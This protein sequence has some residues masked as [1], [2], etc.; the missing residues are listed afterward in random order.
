MT[1]NSGIFYAF[2]SAF[3]MGTIGVSTKL[4]I[5]NFYSFS[6]VLYVGIV[7]TLMLFLYLLFK[8]KHTRI[9]SEFKLR[10]IYY[11]LVGIL[12]MG[13][14][15]FTCITSY[16]FLP[17]SEVVI[18]V[19]TYPLLMLIFARL[20]FKEKISFKSIGFILIGFLGVYLLITKGS[21]TNFTFNWGVILALL[22]SISWG[23]YSIIIKNKKLDVEI[24]M[25]LY[26]FFGTIFL[27]FLSPFFKI[28]FKFSVDV[29]LG[30]L[31]IAIIPV[32]LAFVFWNKA[33]RVTKTTI[34]SGIILL[35]PLISVIL[36]ILFLGENL[37]L[38]QLLGFLIILIAL[39][40]NFYFQK[41][42]N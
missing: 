15:Q 41:K 28:D 1:Q 23:L 24:A 8:K 40:A 38:I 37:V 26:L 33:L 7:A 6:I 9:I 21:I 19:Y 35:T 4:T 39:F 34:C 25:F 14:Q 22:T 2:L 5:K 12:G 16:A 3:F 13:I 30:I 31:Y 32:T 36:N 42:E 20:F 17:A 29:I 10:P 18:L 11:I 27:L